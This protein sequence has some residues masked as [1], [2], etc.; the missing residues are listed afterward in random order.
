MSRWRIHISWPPGP[1]W[2]ALTTAALIGIELGAR[3]F[4]TNDEARFP[5]LAQDILARGDWL[6]PRL[7]G[8][9]YHNKPPLL[10]WLI[11]VLSW[12]EGH[13]SELTAV[14]PSAMSVIAVVWLTFMVA[15]DLSGSEAGSYAALFAMTMQGLFFSAHLALPDPLM[16]TFVT[17]S[18]WMLARMAQEP[19]ESWWIG[20]YGCAG[21]AFWAKGL[22][23]LLPIAVGIGYWIATRSSRRWTLRL[24][25]G[26][27]LVSAIVMVWVV[28]GTVDGS[29]GLAQAVMTDQITWYRPVGF[30]LGSLTAPL[31]NMSVV[32]IPWT[33]VVPL[34]L[35]AAMVA[36]RRSHW[37]RSIRLT[38][39]WLVVTIVLV[40]VSREQ[41][42]RYYA[43]VVPPAAI[44]LGWWISS[45][46]GQWLS[47]A[48]VR[49]VVLHRP[50]AWLW[51]SLPLAWACAVVGFAIGYHVELG[52][53]QRAAEYGA[54]AE[55]IRPFLAEN[56]VV[57][58]WE[59]PELP[60]AFYLDRP[61]VRLE[62][63]SD[64]RKLVEESAGVIVVASETGWARRCSDAKAMSDRE[65]LEPR[66]VILIH[67]PPKVAYRLSRWRVFRR[68]LHRSARDY[69]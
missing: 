13:V 8:A 69:S 15:R 4:A 30:K 37:K 5:L 57:A 46:L 26:S 21:A 16:M 39:V 24:V 22:S 34:A 3:G 43:P 27:L 41:R 52:F 59:L 23:G 1:G 11:A 32:L 38:V 56:P 14:L 61:V 51:C 31:G 19:T 49:P 25:P 35:A 50:A 58:V 33:L 40:A 54:L 12:P 60:L 42:L 62:R 17:A 29:R 47:G 2:I 53:H 48:R 36:C 45:W 7:N 10:A 44:L 64:L 55:R 65:R 6:W 67:R 20:F 68:I 63:E 66:Q 18:V 9:A 28:L